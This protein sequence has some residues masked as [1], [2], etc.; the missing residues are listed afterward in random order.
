MKFRQ[1]LHNPLLNIPLLK[2]LYKRS[3]IGSTMYLMKMRIAEKS[4]PIQIINLIKIK[5]RRFLL[6]VLRTWMQKSNKK[7]RFFV[8]NVVLYD[9]CVKRLEMSFS[10]LIT[11]RC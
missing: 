8:G 11:L 3:P 5:D 1:E 6:V 10:R 4:L 2:Q 7:Y 9:S